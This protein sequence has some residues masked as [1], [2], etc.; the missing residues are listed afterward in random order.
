MKV[1]TW[2]HPHKWEILLIFL[3]FA[4]LEGKVRFHYLV[5]TAVITSEVIMFCDYIHLF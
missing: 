2:A 3:I 1:S 5:D 4:N